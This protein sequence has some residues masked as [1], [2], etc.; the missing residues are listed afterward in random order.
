MQSDKIEDKALGQL[1]GNYAGQRFYVCA[2]LSHD[3][4]TELRIFLTHP[5]FL[6]E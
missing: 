3:A 4:L 6:I 2:L 5:A 1:S